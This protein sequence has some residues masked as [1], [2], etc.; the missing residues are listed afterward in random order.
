MFHRKTRVKKF[1]FSQKLFLFRH[2]LLY[3]YACMLNFIDW[4]IRGAIL[5]AESK[6][7]SQNA[8]FKRRSGAL[9]QNEAIRRNLC[10]CVPLQQLFAR[11]YVFGTNCLAF[12]HSNTHTHTQYTPKAK[13]RQRITAQLVLASQG[14]RTPTHNASRLMGSEIPAKLIESVGILFSPKLPAQTHH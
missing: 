1:K 12:W 8:Y 4:R 2:D 3:P 14:W 5:G 9:H 6:D 7:R 11:I 10:D 13:P